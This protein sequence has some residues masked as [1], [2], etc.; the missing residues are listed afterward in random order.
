MAKSGDM[1]YNGKNMD[2]FGKALS[3]LIEWINIAPAAPVWFAERGL[4]KTLLTPMRPLVELIFIERGRVD[5]RVA[6]EQAALA[7]GDVALVNAHFGNE[8][9]LANESDRYA[10]ISFDIGTIRE[11]S[12]FARS[13]LLLTARMRDVPAMAGAYRDV[14]RLCHSP[15]RHMAEVQIKAAVLRLL[16]T[17]YEEAL[18]G[19]G[20]AGTRPAAVNAALRVLAER[21]AEADLVLPAIAKAAHCSCSHLSR[22][23]RGEIGIG[24]MQY[25]ARLRM[26]RAQHL[27]QRTGMGV[28]EIA[29]CVGVSDP[30]YFSRLFRKHVGLSPRAYRRS[31]AAGPGS[32][33]TAR[34]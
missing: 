21:Q 4:G 25:L 10:C 12:R 28:K 23:F 18:A 16:A 3:A 13:P 7:H 33:E 19:D 27:L 11:L 14:C 20:R 6:G 26:R 9:V 30:L 8:G 2:S 31:A 1:D 32:R 17:T 15:P 34:L 29:A 22:A 5:L 24:P